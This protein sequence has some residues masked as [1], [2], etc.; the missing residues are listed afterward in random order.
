MSETN[1]QDWDHTV[2]LLVVG[3][4]AGA[5]LGPATTFGF[6]AAEDAVGH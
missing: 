5:T 6:I 3:S 2:D 4:G 1:T